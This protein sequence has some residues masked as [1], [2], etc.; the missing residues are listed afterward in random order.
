MVTGLR[1]NRH[2]SAQNIEWEM[3]H[4]C[5]DGECKTAKTTKKTQKSNVHISFVCYIFNAL[6]SDLNDHFFI[7]LFAFAGIMYLRGAPDQGSVSMSSL[8]SVCKAKQRRYCS[9][10]MIPRL[11]VVNIHI[12]AYYIQSRTQI[13]S[14]VQHSFRMP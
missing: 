6:S 1:G 13:E 8:F 4:K 10:A 5:R 3:Q 7:H 2:R 12:F 11:A 9:I 14:P